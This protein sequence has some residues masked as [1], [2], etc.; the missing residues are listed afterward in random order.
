MIWLTLQLGLGL[1]LATVGGMYA[2]G[3]A[4]GAI[5]VFAILK[6]YGWLCIHLLAALVAMLA[7]SLG[8]VTVAISVLQF[9][10]GVM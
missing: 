2:T 6:D 8:V 1:W 4:R 5:E 7:C 9:L 10:R 3:Y